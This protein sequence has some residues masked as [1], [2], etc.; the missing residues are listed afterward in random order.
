MGY[1]GFTSHISAGP[2]YYQTSI[3][4]NSS[5]LTDFF[6]SGSYNLFKYLG[7]AQLPIFIMFIPVG[8]FYLFK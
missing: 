6:Y 8:I 4:N 7:W 5:S 3:E 2:E 1:D